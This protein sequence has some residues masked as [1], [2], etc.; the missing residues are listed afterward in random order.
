MKKVLISLGTFFTIY[1]ITAF[2]PITYINSR[3]HNSYTPYALT[4]PMEFMTEKA[5]TL[6]PSFYQMHTISTAQTKSFYSYSFYI[7]G[8]NYHQKLDAALSGLFFDLYLPIAFVENKLS[9]VHDVEIYAKKVDLADLTLNAGWMFLNKDRGQ[10]TLNVDVSIPTNNNN[11]FEGKAPFSPA[12]GNN[13]RVVS[14]L[15]LDGNGTILKHKNHMLKLLGFAQYHYL[16]KARKQT[17]FIPTN[18]GYNDGMVTV[19]SHSIIDLGQTLCYHY[20]TFYVDCGLYYQWISPWKVHL[21]GQPLFTKN[22][23]QVILNGQKINLFNINPESQ[24]GRVHNA[25]LLQIHAD[26]GFAKKAFSHPFAFHKNEQYPE[27]SAYTNFG[28]TSTLWASDLRS[29]WEVYFKIGLAV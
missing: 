27:M 15:C 11:E 8:L 5:S 3:P 20:K 2:T 4:T 19:S 21:E 29:W 9:D 23:Y 14:G 10:L 16:T 6:A 24:T 7:L 25:N 22:A 12:F 13:G 26:F 18:S 28:F 1:H 17:L